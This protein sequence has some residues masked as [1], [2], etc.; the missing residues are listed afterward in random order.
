MY[1][2]L[3]RFVGGAFTVA[4]ITESLA[5]KSM[6]KQA[7]L[8]VGLCLLGW[9]AMPAHAKTWGQTQ[10]YATLLGQV[11]VICPLAGPEAIVGPDG[12]LKVPP[13][14]LKGHWDSLGLR[15]S[16]VEALTAPFAEEP[17]ELIEAALERVPNQ[18]RDYKRIET[19]EQYVERS[20]E[21]ACLRVYGNLKQLHRRKYKKKE[22]EPGHQI[23]SALYNVA[24][25]ADSGSRRDAFPGWSALATR[26]NGW[27]PAVGDPLSWSWV[28]QPLWPE[29]KCGD[30]E[31]VSMSSP[32]SRMQGYEEDLAGLWLQRRVHLRFQD[33]LTKYA[34]EDVAEYHRA[35]WTHPERTEQDEKNIKQIWNAGI[36]TCTT[37]LDDWRR[38]YEAKMVKET[39]READKHFAKY[40][41]PVVTPCRYQMGNPNLAHVRLADIDRRIAACE[42]ATPEWYADADLG[43]LT[44]QQK[45]ELDTFMTS[46]DARVGQLACWRKLAAANEATC[47]SLANNAWNRDSAL[48]WGA[49]LHSAMRS[50][51]K[52]LNSGQ[53]R[54]TYREWME[55]HAMSCGSVAGI[56]SRVVKFLK[57]CVYQAEAGHH[58]HAW[59][60][61]ER[62]TL[63]YEYGT[64]YTK[65]ADA[66]GGDGGSG[67]VCL[68]DLV[69][70]DFKPEERSSDDT[71]CSMAESYK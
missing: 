70:R 22:Q 24:R 5:L 67:S 51:D 14:E 21:L 18:G 66:L 17:H 71:A 8:C 38:A 35:F 65:V 47:K 13:T 57:S 34:P 9:T 50:Y 3:K 53:T 59:N 43:P 39:A 56:K 55:K 32:Q 25:D 49:C 54:L 48:R 60:P 20:V 63:C 68:L 69:R 16:L 26:P 23:F 12:T 28:G 64:S 44:E 45:S 46:I 1:G 27:D 29:S 15:P 10:Q 4:L 61:P 2:I 40:F 7:A 58:L 36:E 52:Q 31:T 37:R 30:Q 41:A 33:H 6:R 62:L 42:A 11:G 19:P